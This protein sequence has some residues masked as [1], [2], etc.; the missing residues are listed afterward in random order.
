[1]QTCFMPTN[2]CC[3]L[4]TNSQLDK[5]Y[6]ISQNVKLIEVGNISHRA[7]DNTNIMQL[8]NERIQ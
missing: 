4:V 8:N 7:G 6:F 5:N 3:S 1:M 2:S